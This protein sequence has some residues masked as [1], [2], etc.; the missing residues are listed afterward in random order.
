MR[1]E[2]AAD[3]PAADDAHAHQATDPTRLGSHEAS[4]ARTSRYIAVL[5][6]T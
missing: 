3:G 6:G 1:R 5:S 2:E 4:L